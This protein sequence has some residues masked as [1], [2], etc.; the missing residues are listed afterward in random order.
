LSN[1][2]QSFKEVLSRWASGV[3]VFMAKHQDLIYGLTVSSFSSLSLDPPLVTVCVASQNRLATMIE[4]SGRFTVSILASDQLAVSN[5]FST[6]AREPTVGFTS[7]PPAWS[8]AG[9]PWVDGALAALECEVHAWLPHGDHI[10]VAGRVK[11]SDY[12]PDA[13]PL[14]YYHRSYRNVG[15]PIS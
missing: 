3:T 8:E 11:S 5:Y 2:P 15:D 10:I 13:D 1:D 12:R 9:L 4:G 7:V 6:P 14:L